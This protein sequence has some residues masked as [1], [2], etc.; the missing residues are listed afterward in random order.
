MTT[1]WPCT[2][3]EAIGSQSRFSKGPG[4]GARAEV[5][6]GGNGTR[7]RLLMKPLRM[8]PRY[9]HHSKGL[10]FFAVD[11]DINPKER[12]RY[13]FSW[14]GDVGVWEDIWV[15]VALREAIGFT[16]SS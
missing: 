15:P 6:R 2:Y 12:D 4:P 10:A 8:M 1:R 14:W 7:M 16:I 5:L 3:F 13:S 9:W 11:L